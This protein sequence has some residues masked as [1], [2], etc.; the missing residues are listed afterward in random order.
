MKKKRLS[1]SAQNI[2]NKSSIVFSEKTVLLLFFIYASLSGTNFSPF[3]TYG[4]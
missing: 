3:H 1:H 2:T 4:V